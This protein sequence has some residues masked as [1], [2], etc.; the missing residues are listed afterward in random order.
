MY[1]VW[2]SLDEGDD[3]APPIVISSLVCEDFVVVVSVRLEYNA[4]CCVVHVDCHRNREEEG[5][6]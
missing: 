3:D 6:E 1:G 2:N 5:Y 4:P